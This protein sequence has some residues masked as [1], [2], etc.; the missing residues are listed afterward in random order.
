MKEY[1]KIRFLVKAS[2]ATLERP[3]TLQEAEEN[4]YV[5]EQ[6]DLL[7]IDSVLVSTGMN[8]N[9]DVFLASELLPAR[10]TAKHKPMN[11]EHSDDHI[12]GHMISSYISTKEGRRIPESEILANP[13]VVSRDFNV[14][15]ESVM[16]ASIFPD[17]ARKI[18][19]LAQAG[20]L[21]VSVEAWYRDYDYLV[22]NRIVER[23][24][25]TAEYIEQ[26]LRMNGGDGLIEGQ[27]VGRVLRDLII[28]GIGLVETPANK[29]SVIKSVSSDRSGLKVDTKI[30]LDKLIKENTK[31]LLEDDC[32]VLE[33]VMAGEN[34]KAQASASDDK[35]DLEHK[36]EERAKE[37][38]EAETTGEAEKGA[39]ESKDEAKATKDE[40]KADE[41]KKCKKKKKKK[42]K[43]E[44][45][46]EAE[47][48]EVESEECKAEAADQEEQQEEVEKR[49]VELESQI[50]DLKEQV[51]KRD[52]KINAFETEIA[53]LT[54]ALSE[55]NGN[56]AEEDE[57]S[58]KDSTQEQS[59]KDEAKD[60]DEE[61][62]ETEQDAD[63]SE[64]A[65]EEEEEES[66]E[67]EEDDDSETTEE[68]EEPEEEEESEEEVEEEESEESDESEEAEEE[69][70]EKEQ[71]EEEAEDKNE[72]VEEEAE[73]EP[74]KKKPK[75]KKKEAPKKTTKKKKK[76]EEVSSEDSDEEDQKTETEEEAEDE[77]EGDLINLDIDAIEEIL[78]DA[79]DNAEK[80]RETV[81]FK[82]DDDGD[83]SL[84]TEFTEILHDMDIGL[85]MD[86]KED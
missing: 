9:D 41:E 81:Q 20:E 75:Q 44:A 28:A 38:A 6:P 63:G 66:E 76:K 14:D 34:K 37:E 7:R 23:N 11:I 53:E 70:E 3:E 48:Q 60:S 65:V 2:I 40:G 69:T 43:K 8:D 21:F 77:H 52:Q 25:A 83:D 22:G 74:P 19:E 57:D 86:K 29:D 46:S 27:R 15:S 16:Y 49:F 68:D 26:I 67:S 54:R 42:M 79:L 78:Q 33:V 30:D 36:E 64:E 82:S 73:K 4:Q 31:A 50:A 47:T 12:V 80:E 13:L 72:E 51:V 58:S 45:S 5:A 61:E 39:D 85:T 84:Y 59:D 56:A 71:E 17:K 10:N 62:Q 35:G 32:P 24:S 1:K 55:E 18:R